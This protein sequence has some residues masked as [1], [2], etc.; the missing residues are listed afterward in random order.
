MARES[1][2]V[3]YSKKIILLCLVVMTALVIIDAVLCWR[4]EEQLDSCSVAAICGFWGTECFASAWIKVTETKNSKATGD[5]ATTQQPE[6][7]E[8]K[9]G[10][11]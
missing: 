5:K 3:K 8:H 1:N 9:D 11:G 4:A 7:G 10:P 2:G 6:P